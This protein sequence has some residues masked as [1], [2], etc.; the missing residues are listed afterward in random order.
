MFT[1]LG[2]GNIGIRGITLEQAIDLIK[3]SGFE[4]LSFDIQEAAALADARGV[5][6]VKD[7][8]ARAGVV[9]G[10]W[11][12]PVNWRGNEEQYKADLGRLPK[13][14][15]LG[16]ELG[17]VRTATFMGPSSDERQYAENFAWH[18]ARYRPI[19]EILKAEGCRFGI[20]FIGPKTSRKRGKYE[21]IYTLEGLMELAHSIGTGN[22]GLL[23]D[24]WHLYTS[25]G[26]VG[27]LDKVSNQDVVVVHV[28]DA[29]VGIARDDQIDNV[30]ELPMATG[31]IDLPGFMGKLS[32]MGYD[33]PVM[34]EPFS[35]RLN[36]IAATDQ[37][38]AAKIAAESM[39]KLWAAIPQG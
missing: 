33:G 28:N 15:A 22:V 25:G 26:S 37:L 13:L 3:Q 30:R 11:G 36:E 16:R 19:A 24:A 29:P 2:P 18:V 1:C 21:F 39:K 7:L 9:P 14:A 20:E 10:Q 17:C 31:V 23:L 6:Y 34:P 35:A 12:T 8:F 5:A 32:K 4:G 27:D 38:A